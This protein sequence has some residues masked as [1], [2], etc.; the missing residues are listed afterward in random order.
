[1]FERLLTSLRLYIAATSNHRDSPSSKQTD[2]ATD[3]TADVRPDVPHHTSRRKRH[4]HFHRGRHR[5]SNRTRNDNR[6][7]V[8]NLS[9][10]VLSE[11]EISILSKGL[12]FV[13]TPTSVNRTELIAD[14]KKWGRRMRLKEFFWDE[15]RNS[16]QTEQTSQQTEKTSSYKK[17]S[18][19]TPSIGRDPCLDC[20]ITAVE[21]ATME[22]TPNNKQLRSNITRE[23]GNAINTLKR[24][25]NI[26]IFQADKG[27]AVVVQNR[28]DYL[29]EAY[30]QLNGKDQNDDDVY[31]HVPSDPTSDFILR[32][33]E[34]VQD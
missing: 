30:K 17:P 16:Q 28:R 25:K 15:N 34:V 13:P 27:A 23:E 6:N 9:D 31:R 4:R 29:N 18:T 10:R 2:T 8:I 22:G 21:R 33:K 19:W 7:T 20:Y 26:V 11:Q 3:I 12:K 24:D 32:V 14:V 1:M 5:N